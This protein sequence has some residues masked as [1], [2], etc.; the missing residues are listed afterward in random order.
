VAKRITP[1]EIEAF[2][3]SLVAF[4]DVTLPREDRRQM[5]GGM[6]DLFAMVTRADDSSR[7]LRP[8]LRP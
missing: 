6:T 8:P 2:G 5:P 4:R 1:G 3:K 7:P